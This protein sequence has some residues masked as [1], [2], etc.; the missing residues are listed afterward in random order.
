MYRLIRFFSC[1]YIYIEFV[2]DA[3]CLV[4]M[5]VQKKPSM[6]YE[7]LENRRLTGGFRAVHTTWPLDD[8][9]YSL[10]QIYSKDY[11]LA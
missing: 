2:R 9:T 11:R 3:C 6:S 7:P 1:L 4:L 10:Q 8:L 5:D